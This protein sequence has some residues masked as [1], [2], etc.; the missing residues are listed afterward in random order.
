ME[1]N[2]RSRDLN[3]LDQRSD[4]MIYRVLAIA[5]LLGLTAEGLVTDASAG[6]KAA[7]TDQVMISVRILETDKSEIPV[8]KLMLELAGAKD[9]QKANKISFVNVVETKS[10]N[11]IT[12]HLVD[13]A[14]AKVIAEPKLVITDGGTGSFL[15]GGEFPVP[16]IVGVGGAIGTQTSFRGFGIT[17][18]FRPKIDGEF[19]SLDMIPEF[20]ELLRPA[21][22]NGV[23]AVRIRRISTKARI[24]STQSIVISGSFAVN[25]LPEIPKV[26]VLDRI[27]TIRALFNPKIKT[28]DSRL[29]ICVTAE[30]VSPL[31]SGH[32]SEFGT[33]SPRALPKIAKFKSAFD[34]IPGIG[35]YRYPKPAP[36]QMTDPIEFPNQPTQ[37]FISPAGF[38][39]ALKIQ[40]GPAP[41]LTHIEHA[42]PISSASRLQSMRS[43][44]IHLKAASLDYQAATVQS[45]IMKL[46][47]KQTEQ[48]LRQKTQQLKELQSEIAILKQAIGDD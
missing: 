48:K 37:Q 23:P 2:V 39:P 30:R 3:H 20:S 47:R 40:P 7:G 11:K 9:A 5:C 6:D 38:F 15:S 13:Q 27:A 44:L 12:K 10:L 18:T 17:L 34:P 21:T 19:I 24:K 1:Q 16:T 33:A 32:V 31:N 28:N 42:Q 29:L 4:L 25:P 36:P 41:L 22:A 14:K 8:V 45:E 26:P 43:A 35:N 46:V